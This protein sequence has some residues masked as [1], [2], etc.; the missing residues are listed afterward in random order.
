MDGFNLVGI[1]QLFSPARILKPN[2]YSEIE[3]AP[4]RSAQLPQ[5]VLGF[6]FLVSTCLVHFQIFDLPDDGSVVEH[7]QQIAQFF[8]IRLLWVRVAP[9]RQKCLG[10]ETVNDAFGHRAL[11]PKVVFGL[12]FPSFT[13]GNRRC[14]SSAYSP[15]PIARTRLSVC[16]SV[17]FLVARQTDRRRVAT[18]ARLWLEWDFPGFL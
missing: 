14:Q 16:P 15:L 13:T 9:I 18:Q 8:S 5:V 3:H 11:L 1:E 10:R 4:T 7:D 12:H 2:G 17:D 6:G